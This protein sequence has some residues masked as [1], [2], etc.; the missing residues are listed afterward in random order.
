MDFLRDMTFQLLLAI[1]NSPLFQ[2]IMHAITSLF[3]LG[4]IALQK[5][6]CHPALLKRD[7]DSWISSESP[8]ALDRILC[9]IGSTGCYSTSV[10]SGL[11]IASPSEDDPDCQ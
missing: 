10:G 5:T 1:S 7:L 2:P 3:L 8:I 6:L 9:N 11:V 4:G